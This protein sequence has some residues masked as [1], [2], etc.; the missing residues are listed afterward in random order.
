MW[1]CRSSPSDMGTVRDA[2]DP[3]CTPSGEL[4]EEMCCLR[5]RGSGGDGGSTGAES[6][7]SYL[8]MY[9]EKKEEKVCVV[10]RVPRCPCVPCAEPSGVMC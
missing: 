5:L 6:R 7:S 10:C 4:L 2:F 9:K 3:L 1:P 8:E